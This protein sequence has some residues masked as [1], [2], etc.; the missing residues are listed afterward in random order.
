MIQEIWDI[1]NTGAREI[2]RDNQIQRLEE[3]SQIMDLEHITPAVIAA[4]DDM[5]DEIHKLD[6]ENLD[7]KY[8]AVIEALGRFMELM[9]KNDYTVDMN[10]EL[11]ELQEAMTIRDY[12]RVSD[13]LLYDI[14]PSLV[15]LEKSL[16]AETP[17]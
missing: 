14:K 16:L 15:E 17:Q 5:V 11:Q 13:C 10:A 4:M 1:I 12:I 2:V 3:Y 6:S 8:R 9:E 7:I